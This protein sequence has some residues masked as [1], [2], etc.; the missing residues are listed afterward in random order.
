MLSKIAYYAFEHHTHYTQEQN[1]IGFLDCCIRVSDN[2]ARGS[3]GNTGYLGN[4]SNA[5]NMSNSE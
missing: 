4:K 3:M 1:A 2:S 5:G